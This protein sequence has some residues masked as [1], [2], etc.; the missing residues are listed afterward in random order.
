MMTVL[1][2][3]LLLAVPVNGVLTVV[4]V[5]KALRVHGPIMLALALVEVLVWLLGFV[6]GVLV[7]RYLL[8]LTDDGAGGVALAISLLV[9]YGIPT[10]VWLAI[11][12]VEEQDPP[13]PP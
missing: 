10:F 4:T 7:V 9:L 2:W 12:A 6:V 11:R 1:A 8:G 13:A 5:R 3:L